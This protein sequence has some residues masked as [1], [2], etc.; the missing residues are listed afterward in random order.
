MLSLCST[1]EQMRFLV[2]FVAACAAHPVHYTNP[3]GGGTCDARLRIR[4]IDGEH[5]PVAGASLVVVRDDTKTEPVRSDGN[6]FAHVCAPEDLGPG[7]AARLEVNHDQAGH[8]SSTAPFA[9]LV[10]L[11]R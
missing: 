10:V 11:S 8:A 6:G 2:L 7:G 4:V 3:Q 1:N 5:K 9:A